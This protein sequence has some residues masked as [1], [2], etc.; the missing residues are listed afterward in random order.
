MLSYINS[1]S[2]HTMTITV[3]ARSSPLSRTQVKE[4]LQELNYHHP[5]IQFDVHYTTTI[6][7]RDQWTSLRNMERN[8]FFTRDIDQSV[9]QGHC[10]IGIHSAKDLPFPLTEGLSL[11]CLTKGVDSSDSLVLR[12]HDTLHSLPLGACI[13]TSSLRRE[14]I[15]RQL[16]NDLQFC[17][18]RG[19]IDQRLAKLDTREADG[20]VVATAALIRLKLTSLNH[21]ILPGPT[22][23]GQGQLAV[24]GKTEDVE[25]H[26]LFSCLDTRL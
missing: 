11:L 18:L 10:Q 14:E 13:A 7:D 19:T 4:I 9:L 8:D 23:E 22:V 6:G 21:F 25:M 20:V 15:V 26:T 12:P 2:N 24:I 16:R 3:S 5:H 17:D 1:Q